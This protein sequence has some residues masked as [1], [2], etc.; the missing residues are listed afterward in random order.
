MMSPSGAIYAYVLAA[1]LGIVVVKRVI[2]YAPELV[3]NARLAASDRATRRDEA[4]RKAEW[5]TVSRMSDKA[6]EAHARRLD[7]RVVNLNH[8]ADACDHEADRLEA[9]GLHAIP[10]L[11]P[12]IVAHWR[13]Q[14]QRLA[15]QAEAASEELTAFLELSKE[16]AAAREVHRK[17]KRRADTRYLVRLVDSS[18]DT[19]AKS[20]LD[21]LCLRGQIE[22]PDLTEKIQLDTAVRE[23][24][25]KCLRVISAT[26]SIN[27]ARAALKRLK[28]VLRQSGIEWEDLFR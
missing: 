28:A 11:V 15:A 10:L 7:Q 17:D 18:D 4:K 19:A 6:V 3:Y 1:L 20:A 25:D 13:A 5:A 22:W 23:H 27:E 9:S 24:V 26:T 14:G 21:R 2:S 16:V 12:W 8:R